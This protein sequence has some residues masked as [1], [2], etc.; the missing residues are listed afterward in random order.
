MHYVLH[1]GVMVTLVTRFSCSKQHSRIGKLQSSLTMEKIK[2]SERILCI[3]KFCRHCTFG[4]FRTKMKSTSF[5]QQGKYFQ[6]QAFIL[7]PGISRHIKNSSSFV[8]CRLL[9]TGRHLSPVSVQPI[10]AG[11]L[12]SSTLLL[13]QLQAAHSCRFFFFF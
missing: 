9:F 1:Y 7:K 5:W 4:R 10:P 13:M 11:T 8:L 6:Y 12:T 2:V 3:G